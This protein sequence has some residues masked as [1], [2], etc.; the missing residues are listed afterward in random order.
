MATGE[1]YEDPEAPHGRDA[2]GRPR[3]A[4]PDG[5][6]GSDSQREER[7]A[8]IA[9]AADRG[10]TYR[11]LSKQY[12]LSRRQVIRIVQDE[13][14]RRHVEVV[15]EAD[16]M[17][18]IQET[19]GQYEAAIEELAVLSSNS[20]HGAVKVAAIRTRIEAVRSRL[21]LLQAV[22]VVPHNLGTIQLHSDARE[23]GRAIV[24]V[25]MAFEVPEH[26]QDAILDVVEGREVELPALPTASAVPD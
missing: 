22:G 21:E 2:L 9:A 16:P 26:V 15:S 14:A 20:D 6:I 25:L 3:P 19:L 1:V 24:D 23:L 13:R 4:P 10:I 12:G 17:T 18:F 5:P 11:T 7:N 8:V